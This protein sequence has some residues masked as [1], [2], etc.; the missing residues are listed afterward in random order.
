MNPHHVWQTVV[1][2]AHIIVL[3][4]VCALAHNSTTPNQTPAVNILVKHER[5]L[6]TVKRKGTPLTRACA[7]RH[8]A[9]FLWAVAGV[10]ATYQ[11]QMF[12][13]GVRN[14]RPGERGGGGGSAVGGRIVYD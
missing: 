9:F 5:S 12:G 7:V 11:K 2:S 8:A 6:R 3:V 13:K 14:A 10:R 4:H 1:R